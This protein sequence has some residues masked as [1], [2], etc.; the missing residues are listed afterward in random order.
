MSPNRAAAVCQVAVRWGEPGIT[1]YNLAKALGMAKGEAENLLEYYE[2]AGL[3]SRT[4]GAVQKRYR[5]TQQGLR[6]AWEA[7]TRNL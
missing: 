1:A 3:L 4:K 6:L 5:P 2:S 7:S